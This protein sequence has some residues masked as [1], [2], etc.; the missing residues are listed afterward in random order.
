MATSFDLMDAWKVL[1]RIP[2]VHGPYFEDFGSNP[3]PPFMF[4]R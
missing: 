4:Y 3:T 1:W 2:D